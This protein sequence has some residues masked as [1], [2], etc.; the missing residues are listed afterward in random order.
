MNEIMTKV[1]IDPGEISDGYHTFDELYLQ[2]RVL[3]EALVRAYPSYAWKSKLHS[4]GCEPFG[5]GWFIVGFNTPAGQF[6]YHYELEYWDNFRCVEF[7]T[8]PEWDGHT[9][10]DVGRLLSLRPICCC[11]DCVC[12]ED[13]GSTWRVWCKVYECYKD[14]EAFCNYG[15]HKE[16]I[17]C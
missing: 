7:P 3:T 8:A 4:D 1:Q 17:P 11:Q 5:G 6:T 12:H 14:P 9:C 16:D 10:E 2:R 13:R 15:L